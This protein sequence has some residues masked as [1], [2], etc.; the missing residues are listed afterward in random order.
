MIIVESTKF[1]PRS[2]RLLYI[3]VLHIILLPF[4]VYANKINRQR[5]EKAVVFP[6]TNYF[7]KMVKI[8]FIP[9]LLTHIIG[10]IDYFLLPSGDKPFYWKLL[11][12]ISFCSLFAFHI[13]NTV[14]HVLIMMMTLVKFLVYFFPST[15]KCSLSV[16]S[17]FHKNLKLVYLTLTIKDLIIRYSIGDRNAHKRL[18]RISYITYYGFNVLL[19]ISALLYIPIL[20][21]IRKHSYLPSF[22]EHHPQRYIFWQTIVVFIF[23]SITIL[24]VIFH[25]YYSI[26]S[27]IIRLE[28]ETAIEM[29]TIPLIIEMSYLGCNKRNMTILF[30][31][32]KL[33]HFLKVIF[34][35]ESSTVEP[36]TLANASMNV[37]T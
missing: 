28:D 21:N 35:L 4:Y 11:N 27:L 5:D 15:E 7:Y 3:P 23:K 19:L 34:G 14:F 2:T 13:N 25:A 37:T 33:K 1:M 8:T 10:F 16:Q 31:S 9:S 20:I 30:T 12:F 18:Y 32:F 22:Q 17:F 24:S 26:D 36:Q 6:I 29:I